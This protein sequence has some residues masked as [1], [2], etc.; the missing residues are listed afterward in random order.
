MLISDLR[1]L[2]WLLLLGV[3]AEILILYKQRREADSARLTK[4][5]IPAWQEYE[6]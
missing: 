3:E 1:L 5:S 4:S 6:F 2:L